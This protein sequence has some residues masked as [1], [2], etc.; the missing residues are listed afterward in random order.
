MPGLVLLGANHDV[1]PLNVREKLAVSRAEVGSI[2]SKLS[3]STQVREVFILSTKHRTEVYLRGPSSALDDI[4]LFWQERAG[5]SLEDLQPFLYEKRDGEAVCHLFALGAGLDSLA[6]GQSP[7]LAQIKEALDAAREAGT[8]GG[9][10]DAL[11][12]R[13]IKVS[14][15]TLR[16]NGQSTD[17]A[18]VEKT[19]EMLRLETERFIRWT[20]SQRATRAIGAMEQR[21]EEI[22][23]AEL[24]KMEGKL[25]HL[26]PEEREALEA[27]T[28]SIVDKLL[29]T[30]K[31]ALKGAASLED[32]SDYLRAAAE[33][34]DLDDP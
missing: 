25:R 30:P 17:P 28:A 14:K 15:K 31:K 5:T 21:A 18:Q 4:R 23:R 6:V 3:T 24:L 33:L 22:R 19:R 20:R 9:Y 29:H 10:L 12:N 32:A 16:E 26:S 1:A 2:L 7:A 34:F 8:I 27:L 11:L 13:A